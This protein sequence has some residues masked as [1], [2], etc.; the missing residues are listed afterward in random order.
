MPR[1]NAAVKK[2][3]LPVNEIT[4]KHLAANA[5]FIKFCPIPPKSCLTTKIANTLPKIG[6]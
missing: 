6:M 5:G 1:R 3:I 2:E 4:R